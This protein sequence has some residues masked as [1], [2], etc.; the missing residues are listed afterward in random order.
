MAKERNR[1]PYAL[2][3]SLSYIYSTFP[4]HTPSAVLVP[5]VCVRACIPISI[6][7]RLPRDYEQCLQRVT[8]VTPFP[9]C[10]ELRQREPDS[11]QQSLDENVDF[12]VLESICKLRQRILGVEFRYPNLGSFDSLSLTR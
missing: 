2:S 6:P 7:L 8:A 11:I 3:L 5:S 1:Y 4:T 9:I 10:R 12:F